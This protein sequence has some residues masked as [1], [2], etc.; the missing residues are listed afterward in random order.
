[1]KAGDAG[2]LFFLTCLP[3]KPMSPAAEQSLKRGSVPRFA[4]S[5][6]RVETEVCPPLHP[7]GDRV[8]TEV[9][10]PL[11]PGRDRIETEVCPPL[12]PGGDRVETGVCPP[13]QSP[14]AS[15]LTAA[16]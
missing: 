7:G 6:D 10:P 3:P 8:E 13:L 16:A 1:M 5:G 11:H 2:R 15:I 9:C 12:H 4:L 14:V